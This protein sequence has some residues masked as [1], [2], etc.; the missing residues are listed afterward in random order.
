M[1][2]WG[3]FENV[4]V[5]PAHEKASVDFRFRNGKKV[6]LVAQK[7]KVEQLLDDVKAYLKSDPGQLDW[8]KIN[9]GN[10]GYRLVTQG[11]AKY[12]GEEVAKWDLELEPREN[13]FDRRITI[14]RRC[15]SGRLPRHR[16]DGR[17]QRQQD[18]P[19][20][21][22][23]GDREEAARRQ[24]PVLRRRRRGR[25]T[26]QGAGL[27]FFGF[28]QNRLPD[29]RWQ[30][31]TA[32]FSDVTNDEGMLIPDNGKLTQEFSWLITAKNKAGRFA[33]LGFA[34][35]W[36]AGIHDPEYNQIK[37]FSHHRSPGLSPRPEGEVQVLGADAH[38][39]TR[40]TSR[41]SPARRSRSNSTT[42]GARRFTP[43][44]WRPTSTAAATANGKCR[45]TLRSVS[46]TSSSTPAKGTSGTPRGTACS[47]SR[48][49]RSPSSK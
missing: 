44:A 31:V 8:N 26:G 17:R 21:E 40:K 20:G 33:Y 36:T 12:I 47:A 29:G 23:H 28:R 48:S 43:R 1:K 30:T 25:Q 7:V 6:S 10:I 18:H 3:S 22:R 24:E 37:V 35:V 49:T 4:G 2:N 34:G 5:Q 16:E 32:E 42:R 9:I 45:P 46:T 14:E 41:S 19:L 15:R 27:E 11:E 39:T 13:H 38:N